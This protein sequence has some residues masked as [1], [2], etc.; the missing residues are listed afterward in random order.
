MFSL[1]RKVA[2]TPGS[3][4]K[5]WL[6]C[7]FPFSSGAPSNM[8]SAIN[9]ANFYPLHWVLLN[10]VIKWRT[11]TVNHLDERRRFC[12]Y[13]PRECNLTADF[14]VC[15]SWHPQISQWESL[16]HYQPIRCW[17]RW[18]LAPSNQPIMEQRPPSTN[19]MLDPLDLSTLMGL[20]A[21]PTS[22]TVKI[23]LP[24]I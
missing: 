3:V 1:L 22:Q 12:Q 10:S 21:N 8:K 14:W 4:D 18:I 7:H 24:F 2:A 13:W 19:Q 16:N 20:E 23:P 9:F 11:K 15:Y 6:C 5:I 17:I